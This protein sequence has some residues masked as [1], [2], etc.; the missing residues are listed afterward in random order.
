MIILRTALLVLLSSVSLLLGV[1]SVAGQDPGWALALS[2]G[3]TSPVGDFYTHQDFKARI[4]S[5]GWGS[6]TGSYSVTDRATIYLRASSSFGSGAR[7]RLA[8]DVIPRLKMTR[9]DGL[10]LGISSGVRLRAHAATHLLLGLGLQG[11]TLTGGYDD[12]CVPVGKECVGPST[13]GLGPSAVGAEVGIVQGLGFL[14]L[15]R[16]MIEVSDFISRES[17]PVEPALHHMLR[18]QLGFD[19]L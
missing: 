18:F 5:S 8:S 9:S 13:L 19:F 12:W 3:V 11:F 2:A 15:N 17:D 1:R 10:L 14:G 6:V 16:F 7:S 4:R